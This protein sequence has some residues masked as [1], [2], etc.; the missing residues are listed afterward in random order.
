MM[1]DSDS[2]KKRNKLGYQRISIACGT[3][4]PTEYIYQPQAESHHPWP[5]NDQYMGRSASAMDATMGH[6]AAPT[7]QYQDH[8]PGG[9]FAP[10]PTQQATV[11]A[12]PETIQ[13]ASYQP[14]PDPQWQHAQQPLNQPMRSMSYS[15][16]E[17]M[18]GSYTPHPYDLP[19]DPRQQ[20]S[21]MA[22][23]TATPD[24]Q[25]VPSPMPPTH[26]SEPS[27]PQMQQQ[28][29]YD[30]HPH[31]VYPQGSGPAVGNAPLQA[32]PAYGHNWYAES[33][34]FVHAQ[35]EQINPALE[36]R[37]RAQGRMRRRG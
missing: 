13:T 23:H 22:Y 6:R 35:Q 12:N 33:S 28:L 5:P 17:G 4:S 24:T 21:P 18:S 31:F 1:A 37:G 30:Q 10:F 25:N 3:I 7:L 15:H 19:P 27:I 16:A 8:N 14:W 34:P 36:N 29:M 26:A 20:P 9:D 2:D 11:G 32:H